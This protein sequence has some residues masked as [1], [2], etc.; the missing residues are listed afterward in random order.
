ML[1][2]IFVRD[3]IGFL[4]FEFDDFL[5]LDFDSRF[6]LVDLIFFDLDRFSDF[7]I[8]FSMWL[9]SFYALIFFDGRFLDEADL[10]LRLLALRFFNLRLLALFFRDF[11]DLE[12]RLLTLRSFFAELRRLKA[13][14]TILGG[15]SRSLVGW[16][17][18]GVQIEC[19]Y[20]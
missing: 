11:A 4:G 17:L 8:N 13:V 3:F 9:S 19:L 7:S 10:L 6:L 16:V 5:D 18:I 14:E 20:F 15:V 1:A 2:N 12:L